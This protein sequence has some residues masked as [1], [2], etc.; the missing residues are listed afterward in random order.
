M[1]GVGFRPIAYNFALQH[2]LVGYVCN[3]GDG[4]HF[5]FNAQKEQQDDIV[6]KFLQ[7]TPALAKINSYKI[8]EIEQV[9]FTEF[10]ITESVTDTQPTIPV[11]P[12]FALCSSCKEE[13][14]D[15]TN[16][17]YRYPF[18]TC[19]TCGPRYSITKKLP[20]DRINTTMQSFAMCSDCATEYHSITNRRYFSQTNS[21]QT[22]GIQLSVYNK[23]AELIGTGNE[24]SL[25]LISQFLKEGKIVAVK[26]TGGFLLF[27]DATNAN[28][29]ELLRKRKH[30]PAKPF[31]VLCQNI[32][33]AQQLANFNEEAA[34]LMT[35]EVAP[36]VLLN[37]SE[38]I[39]TVIAYNNIALGLQTI[40]IMLPNSPLLDIVCN[41]FGKPMICTS[42]NISGSPIICTNED[43]LGYLTAIADVVV[44]HNRD[45]VTPQDDSVIRMTPF[46]NKQIV[47]RRSRG[48]APNVFSNNDGENAIAFG[49]LMKSSI[50]IQ[51]N[52]NTYVSQFLGNTTMLESQQMYAHTFQNLANVIQA[53]PSIVLADKHPDYFATQFAKNI[54]EELTVPIEYIQHHKAHFAAVLAEN[55]LLE[56]KEE[57]LGVIWDGTG[58]GD[59]GNTWGGEF[60]KYA[61]RTM[62]RCY[63]FDYF[64][65]LIGDKMAKEPRLSALCA[66][67]DAINI[68]QFV[69]NKF[70]ETE[71]SLYNAMLAK[72]V[73]MQTSSAGRIFD[74]VASLLGLCDKQSYEGEAAMLLETAGQHYYNKNGLGFTETYY[75][76]GAHYHRLPTATL[77]NGVCRDIAKG[78]DKEFI[79]AKFHYSL[80]CCIENIAGYTHTKTIAFSGGVFQ[81]GLLIDLLHY[82]LGRKF[83]LCFHKQL[84]PNDEN[85][86]YGQIMYWMD[87]V[88]AATLLNSKQ[89]V[90][91][92]DATEVDNST[93]AG[94]KKYLQ[95]IK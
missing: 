12:D 6:N 85:I 56:G 84:S 90:Q 67:Y 52:S 44:T 16:R 31:A 22:C 23:N 62:Q 76:P 77:I 29:I 51:Q 33:M 42:A 7:H 25:L 58:L 50:A 46:Y 19:T 64:P 95:S 36:V 34:T 47:I 49:A 15:A 75:M 68:E 2:G 65:L 57:V 72:G 66:T 45:I 41:D 21:C 9:N 63:Y 38:N 39:S 48:M 89:N 10:T 5:V 27:C 61:N 86:S 87:K 18:I 54:A 94:N 70:S 73:E 20:Y 1:Q 26:N 60:F 81:N 30:R 83:Q 14:N 32:K 79:A 74:A 24:Q 37:A 3:S 8:R 53:K 4:L 17:R 13:L 11:T 35:N 71:W 43:A 82:H 69:K 93:K 80:V 28:S 55:N 40:G 91:E 78:K 59:D 88:D 92:C